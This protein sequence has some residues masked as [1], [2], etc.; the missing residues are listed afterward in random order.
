MSSPQDSSSAAQYPRHGR[1]RT[2][3]HRGGRRHRR[4]PQRILHVSCRS[5]PSSPSPS[6]RRPPGS[7]TP[8]CA[9][10]RRE[11]AADRARQAQAYRDDRRAALAPSTASSPTPWRPASVSAEQA[12]T[13]LEV[14]GRRLPG[15][16]GRGD[17]QAQRRG[18][19]CRRGRGRGQPA[20]GRPST[21][22][23]SEPPRRSSASPSS[24]TRTTYSAP[25]TASSGRARRRHLL[26]PGPPRLTPRSRRVVIVTTRRI[27]RASLRRLGA[28]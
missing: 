1:C 19:P 27:L 7:P 3:H 28:F 10:S 4:R 5:L 26:A 23:R 11:A 22:P 16:R 8:S 20:G 9:V 12:V 18:P 17:A 24:S 2:G 21:S 25:R 14:R 15:P 6:E 13:Q